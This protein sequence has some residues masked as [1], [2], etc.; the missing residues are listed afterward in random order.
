G[1][2]IERAETN[3]QY[4]VGS[5]GMAAG[6][7]H[8]DLAHTSG[9]HAARRKFGD[10]SFETRV[11][12]AGSTAWSDIAK[13]SEDVGTRVDIRDA[14]A[15]QL[16]VQSMVPPSADHHVIESLFSYRRHRRRNLRCRRLR[17]LRF[18]RRNFGNQ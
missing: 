8:E 12:G 13:D 11:H 7:H 2:A 9:K 15:H 18:R 5:N 6:R 4:R 10:G 3:E 16:D 14:A 17:S 1:K